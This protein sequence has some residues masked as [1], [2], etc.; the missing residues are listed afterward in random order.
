ML[1]WIN[2]LFPLSGKA[3]HASQHTLIDSQ[4]HQV[5]DSF[6][7]SNECK[8]QGDIYLDQGD[9]ARAASCYREAIASNPNNAAA[10]NNLGLILTDQRRYDEAIAQ[11]KQA[12]QLDSQSYNSFYM[13]GI[14]AQQRSNIDEAV[15]HFLQAISIRPDFPAALDYLGRLLREQGKLQASVDCYRKASSLNPQLAATHSDLLLALQFEGSSTQAELFAE[16]KRF[17]A[18]FEAPLKTTRRP[19]ANDKSPERRLK[20]GYVSPDFRRHSVALFVLP[21]LTSHDQQQFEIFCYSIYPEED[22]LTAEIATIASHFVRCAGMSDDELAQRIRADG[23]DILVDLAGHTAH[24]RLPVFARKP[25]PVQVSYLGYIDTT[26][27]SAMDYRL[28]HA[29][30]DPPGNEHYYSE[31]LI[32][33]QDHLW[34]AYRPAPDLPEISP[35]PALA[36]GFVTFSS[37]NH[38][39]KISMAML[40]TWAELLHAVPDSR[41]VLMG[42]SSGIARKS[43]EERFASHGIDCGRLTFHGMVPLAEYRQL[44]LQT[45]ISLDSFP[46]NGGTTTCETLW[47]GLPLITL[48]GSSFVSRMGYALLKEIGL[49]ELAANNVAQYV[50]IAAELAQNL[51]RLSALR[52]GLREHVAKSSL[53]DEDRFT[54]GLES[55]YRDMWKAYL[56]SSM[57]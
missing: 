30:T 18:Q 38:V 51:E 52:S 3:A 57:Q 31:T 6:N 17:A 8:N 19:H 48:T 16:H 5:D 44:L 24:N 21:I 13:L 42:I 40:D 32:R 26:G 56:T 36:N 1:K 50:R 22:A 14:I 45:D 9:L 28:T 54:R 43:F 35:L 7:V 29:D 46:Y 10:H 12:I 34:W 25:A 49:S 4:P 47:L 15:D 23:I 27:L 11:F 41:L 37:N 39:S 53:S 33:F 2:K 55:A 20:I